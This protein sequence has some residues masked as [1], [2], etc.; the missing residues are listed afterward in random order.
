[1]QTKPDLHKEDKQYK[2]NDLAYTAR[3]MRRPCCACC[4][5]HILG[6]TYLDLSPFGLNGVACEACVENNT[7][8]TADLDADYE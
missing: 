7:A 2:Q 1:M 3:I 8:T 4:S 5:K 6:E